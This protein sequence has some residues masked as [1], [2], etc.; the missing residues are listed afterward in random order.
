MKYNFVILG[1]S[2]F[3]I[4]CANAIL[5]SGHNVSAMISMPINSVPDNSANIEQYATQKNISYYE[6]MDINSPNSIE[7]LRQLKPN[8]ITTSC[9]KII[10]KEVL[11]V[12]SN[13]CIGTHPTVLPFNRGAIHSTGLLI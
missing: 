11:N 1:T 13:F 7:I 8:Y 6:F 12:P 4:Y 3:D 2:Q 9:P 5:D 10:G